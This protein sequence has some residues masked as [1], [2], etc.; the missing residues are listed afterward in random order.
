[1]SDIEIKAITAVNEAL[2]SIDDPEILKRVLRWANDKFGFV[3][4]GEIIL[5]REISRQR[6][7]PSVL[8]GA[9]G[10][11]PGIA[12]LTEAGELRLTV[13]DLKA[14][15][16]NDAALRLAHIAIRAYQQLTGQK[17]MSSKNVLVPLLKDWRVYDGNTR[18]TL[19]RHK[20]IIRNGDELGLDFHAQA[21]AEKFIKEALDNSIEGTWK[22]GAKARKRNAPSE[23]TAV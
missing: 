13:R 12:M 2:G 1:M 16:A 6:D 5:T 18:A 23:K 15:S 7:M 8:E 22:P 9:T 14:K 3:P 11:I 19:A 4:S 21:D 20:G 17:T 10:E